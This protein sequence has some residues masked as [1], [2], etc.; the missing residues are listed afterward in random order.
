MRTVSR[1]RR[2]GVAIA[3]PLLV[4]ALALFSGPP[5][6]PAA[7][8]AS[9]GCSYYCN[10]P[11]IQYDKYVDL[12]QPG[13][14][15][16]ALIEPGQSFHVNVEIY[17]PYHD[18]GNSVFYGVSDWMG[19]VSW[20]GFDTSQIQEY[21]QG[22]QNWFLYND[23]MTEPIALELSHL[24]QDVCGTSCLN[25]QWGTQRY[26]TSPT[27]WGFSGTL[28]APSSPGTYALHALVTEY[29]RIASNG[30]NT[31]YFDDPIYTW[32]I[33]V[34]YPS[35]PPASY[36]WYSFDGCYQAA[37]GYTGGPQEW[38]DKWWHNGATGTNTLVQRY[39]QNWDVPSQCDPHTATW[40]LTYPTNFYTGSP[41]VQGYV[42][43]SP[44]PAHSAENW[45][46]W[47]QYQGW[48]GKYWVAG[49]QDLP[50]QFPTP[51]GSPGTG[52]NWSTCLAI[53]GA[54]F[55]YDGPL[56]GHG[57]YPGAWGPW[58]CHAFEAYDGV[59]QIGFHLANGDT[60]AGQ[61]VPYLNPGPSG[62]VG[63]GYGVFNIYVPP[64]TSWVAAHWTVQGFG[65]TSWG[66]DTIT[67]WNPF[68]NPPT[69]QILE[70]NTQDLPTNYTQPGLWTVTLQVQDSDGAWSPVVSEF[71]NQADA[72]QRSFTVGGQQ[73][74]A[75]VPT[76]CAGVGEYSG[77]TPDTHTYWTGSWPTGVNEHQW[78]SDNPGTQS[79]TD[80]QPVKK[81]ISNQPLS[82]VTDQPGWAW[83]V[84]TYET[85]L[86]FKGTI[87]NL[88][89]PISNQYEKYDPYDCPV[90]LGY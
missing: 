81:P 67:G 5:M 30:V 2:Y 20:P 26:Q 7:Y 36:T 65:N 24:R 72:S 54:Y 71:T 76:G 22:L 18:S 40:H 42:E 14:A 51:P 39:L 17:D 87:V 29:Q 57:W 37:A 66:Y 38:I 31:W 4:A 63:Q 19:G 86:T 44:T 84:D 10:S 45:V 35:S 48:N 58:S 85:G 49:A 77:Y 6:S 34:G 53:Q 47:N 75:F 80:C 78:I 23:Y 33:A 46:Q 9:G 60:A 3:L 79:T 41:E 68:P 89:A 16:P 88:S 52:E 13:I 59:P 28:T 62:N 74:S 1:W 73:L 11:Q 43:T 50:T 32:Y 83:W 69:A 27:T 15:V 25:I 21:M 56:N 64:Y 8:A 55:Y 70:P 12:R 61:P 90:P 82:C